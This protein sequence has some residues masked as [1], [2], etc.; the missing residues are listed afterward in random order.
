MGNASKKAKVTSN[1]LKGVV[2]PNTAGGSGKRGRGAQPVRSIESNANN[3]T[4]GRY[5]PSSYGAP[6]KTQIAKVYKA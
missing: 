6:Y 1:I 2:H 3:L 4:P 5:W